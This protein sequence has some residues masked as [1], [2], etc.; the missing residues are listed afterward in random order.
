M[1]EFD[2]LEEAAVKIRDK[3]YEVAK[4][5]KGKIPCTAENGAFDDCSG[6][7][8]IGT[9]TNGFYGGIQWQLYN[10]TREPLFLEN[11]MSIEKKLD[12]VLMD[13]QAMGDGSGLL[14][15]PTAVANF[16]M[17]G[18]RPARNRALLAANNLA[19]RF[20]PNGNFLRAFNDPDAGENT[21][22]KESSAGTAHIR[23]LMSLPLLYWASEVT[24]DP[25]FRTIAV[26]HAMTATRDFI[27]E[28]GSVR[29]IVRYDPKTGDSLDGMECTNTRDNTDSNEALE[30][31]IALYGFT[32]SFFHTG[33]SDFL[34]AAEKTAAFFLSN[35]PKEN[36]VSGSDAAKE[37][38]TDAAKNA[39]TNEAKDTA[40]D[41]AGDVLPG[42]A[43][44]PAD[45]AA[46][47]LA[48]SGLVLLAGLV[49][50]DQSLLTPVA[51]ALSA[52]Y[53][54]AALQLLKMLTEKRACFDAGRDELLCHCIPEQ[55]GRAK[56]DGA[57][58]MMPFVYAD[59]F[60]IEAVWRLTGRE[61]LIW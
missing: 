9:R 14:W 41:T 11:A 29:S 50:N 2:W 55:Y 34:K 24:K 19:G 20:N 4:R 10:A 17:T 56:D 58:K 26:R 49:G 39:V 60:Y 51:A 22:P 59:Y 3:E 35:C 8:K 47:A 5:N 43:P 61:L 44:F 15:M 23:T 27:Q 46:A 54:K 7:D 28:D 48:S 30:Q 25:R 13:A 40:T 12:A 31:A 18:S 38:F 53:R 37:T 6:A 36:M 32:L 52:G 21:K 57:Q 16:H 45:D 33:E 1:G 42:N